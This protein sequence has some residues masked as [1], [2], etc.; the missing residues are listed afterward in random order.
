MSTIA[1]EGIARIVANGEPWKERD[2][3]TIVARKDFIDRNPDVVKAW[4]KAE[5]E[6]QMWYYDPRNHAE[7]LRIAAKYVPGF[8]E[9]SLWFSLAGLIPTYVGTDRRSP[10][11]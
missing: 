7:V 4:L 5:I 9:K 3:G 8:T 11:N 1:G 2:S 10:A 6:T